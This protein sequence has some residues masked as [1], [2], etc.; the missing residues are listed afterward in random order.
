VQKE[1]LRNQV[2]KAKNNTALE[3]G[4]RTK[5]FNQWVSSQDIWISD[6]L[7]LNSSK[8]IDM[9]NFKDYYGYV[10]VDLSAVSDITALSVM[11]PYND[12]YIFKT[13]YYL[14]QTCL[15]NNS[16]CELYK[17]WAKQGYLRITAGNVVDY[18]YIKT[19]LQK[20]SST[21]LI[22]KVAYDSYNATQWAISCTEAGLPLE[23]FSQALW[24]FNRATKEFERLIKQGKIIIDN[25]EITRWMFRNV[26]LKYDHNDNVKPVKNSDMQKI[27]GVIAMLEALGIYLNVP[28][29]DVGL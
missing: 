10:G 19:D 1:Y 16:N 4:V 24:N 22:S 6:E 7:L 17:K 15:A 18:D 25:N 29:Y 11:I 27:D 23:P 14:P 21:V 2:L 20:V 8:E 13:Y 28:H 26:A 9:D 12:K 3:V 5:N